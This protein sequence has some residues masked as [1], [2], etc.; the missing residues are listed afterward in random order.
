MVSMNCF[1]LLTFNLAFMIICIVMNKQDTYKYT[2]AIYDETDEWNKGAIVDIK[3]VSATYKNITA[4]VCG[5]G[6]E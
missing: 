4:D 1:T 5:V 3:A 6:Y 2:G